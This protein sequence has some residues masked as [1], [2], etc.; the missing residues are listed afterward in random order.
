M[1]GICPEGW[2]LP[3]LEETNSLLELENVPYSL[4]ALGSTSLDFYEKGEISPYITDVYGFAMKLTSYDARFW[5]AVQTVD[6]GA[7]TFCVHLDTAY[8]ER[9]W[10]R[11]SSGYIRCVE[12]YED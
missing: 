10:M 3:T 9:E 8:V 4:Y 11:Y 6:D 12:D 1:R 7:F 2:H 5:S